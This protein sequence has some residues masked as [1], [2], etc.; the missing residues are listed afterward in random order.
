MGRSRD[1]GYRLAGEISP[2]LRPLPAPTLDLDEALRAA[3][4][5]QVLTPWG[6]YGS[7]SG[8]LSFVSLTAF[9]PLRNALVLVL[10]DRGMTLRSSDSKGTLQAALAPEAKSLASLGSLDGIVVF[11]AAEAQVP[12]AQI[13]DLLGELARL[14]ARAALAVNLAPGTPL[15]ASSAENSAR[16]CPDGLSATELPEADLPLDT[17]LSSVSPLRE[18]A[19][20]C[21]L[22]GSA[23]G[24]A[25]GKL[26]LAF[27]VNAQGSVQESCVRADEI[28]DAQVAA[29]LLDLVSKL[30]FP[31]PEPAGGVLDAE[32]P[33]VLRP[34]SAPAQ[35]AVC[36]DTES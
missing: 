18:R 31:A 2:G 13:Y 34:H 3:T 12:V 11:V 28:G 16:R 20:E 10:T 22:R 26:T 32:L 15:P 35:A 21:L 27:R 5:V 8:A 29:C 30:Q 4:S 1:A 14:G 33:L 23:A 25:G 24:A 36:L 6:A 19:H 9:P 7:H 17:L